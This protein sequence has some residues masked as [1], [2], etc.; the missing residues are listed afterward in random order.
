MSSDNRPLSPHLQIYRW[1]IT[2][3]MSIL[4]RISGVAL[5]IGALLLTWWLAAAATGPDYFSLVQYFASSLLGR[6]VL[7]GFVGAL[8]FHLCNGIRHLFW[9]AG[10][11]LEMAS[12][13]N[14]SWL[15]LIASIILTILVF[16]LGYLFG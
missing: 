7:L 6:L 5:G 9:D 4:H 12:A 3:A 11:G 13:R 15:V 1:H 14:S 8:C 16:L 10:M 2:M